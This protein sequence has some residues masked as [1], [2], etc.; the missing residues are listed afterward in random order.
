M[1][2]ERQDDR[3]IITFEG[4]D[5]VRDWLLAIAQHSYETAVPRGLG[6][7]QAKDKDQ[8]APRLEDCIE[9]RIELSVPRVWES[10]YNPVSLRMDYINGRDCRT[11]VQKRTAGD[12]YFAAYAFEQRKVTLD[13]FQRG[14]RKENAGK[15]LDEVIKQM[16]R[17]K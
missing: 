3:V 10:G 16:G 17:K 11:L 4:K 14:I 7:L 13:E 9:Y 2:Y 1:K 5:N 8:I 15:F 12:W 6:H